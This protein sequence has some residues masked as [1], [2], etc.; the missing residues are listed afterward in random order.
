[1]GLV[2]MHVGRARDVVVPQPMRVIPC[3]WCE[4]AGI[5]NMARL[6]GPSAPLDFKHPHLSVQSGSAFNLGLWTRLA[7]LYNRRH[8]HTDNSA[9]TLRLGRNHDRLAYR[10]KEPRP[11]PREAITPLPT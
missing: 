9:E 6:H 4:L 5:I 10:I 8:L 7:G 1:M 2:L 11:P 3:P